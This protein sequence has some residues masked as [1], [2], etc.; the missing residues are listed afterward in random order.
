MQFFSTVR[1][2]GAPVY[3]VPPFAGARS[4]ILPAP[5]ARFKKARFAFKST[6]SVSGLAWSWAFGAAH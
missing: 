5:I 1:V 3:V 4:F 6:V 2:F